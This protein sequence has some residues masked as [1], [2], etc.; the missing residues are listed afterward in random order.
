MDEQTTQR[1]GDVYREN[2]IRTASR[3]QLLLITY[4]IG[5]RSCVAAEIAIGSRDIEG[6]NNNLKRAQAVVRELMLTLN[7]DAGGEVVENLMR[8]YDFLYNRLVEANVKKDAGLVA[9]V[10]EMLESLRATWSEA[11][12][13]LRAE[14]PEE[15]PRYAASGRSPDV[16]KRVSPPMTAGGVNFA[17]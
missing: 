2:Q 7:R 6:A 14:A 4:D 1:A 11:I 13:K 10:R 9:S 17:G 15:I 16:V 8:L 3:E 12:E 5:I